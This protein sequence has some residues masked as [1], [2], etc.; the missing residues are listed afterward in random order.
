MAKNTTNK[1]IISMKTITVSFIIP[2]EQ[3]SA[4]NKEIE[5]ALD[6]GFQDF[7]VSEWSERESTEDECD[8]YQDYLDSMF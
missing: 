1:G 6:N 5:K 7:M 8:N 2:E 4:L 3:S